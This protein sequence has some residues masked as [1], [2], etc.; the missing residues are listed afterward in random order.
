MSER[1]YLTEGRFI[2]FRGLYRITQRTSRRTKTLW[3]GLG[4][5][6][7]FFIVLAW[8]QFSTPDMPDNDGYYHIRFA[9]LMRTQG[10]KPDFPWLPLT[11]LNPRE[12]YDHHFLFHVALIP[13]TFGDLRLGAK[14]AS[15]T[16][17]SL[18]FLSI[19]WLLRG[20]RVRYAALWALGLLVVSQAFLF[21]MSIT[22]AQSLSLAVLA[23]GLHWMF[24]GKYK[25]LLP[26]AFVYVWMYDAFPLLILAALVYML[27]VWLTERRLDPSP[28]IYTSAGVVLGLVI[29]PYFPANLVFIYR[30]LL[31]K[32][33]ET[34]TVSVGNEWY[35]YTTLQLSQNSSLALLAFLA[36]VLALGLRGERI[37]ARTAT[38][39]F[40]AVL[41]GAMLF[42]SRR[43]IEYYAPFAVVFA[44]L[45]WTPLLRI[46]PA[47]TGWSRASVRTWLPGL[48]LTTLLVFGAWRTLPDARESVQSSKPYTL[49]AAATAWLQA[50]T[51]PGERIFQTD[52]DD[53]PRLFFYNTH[54]TYLIGLDPTY[55]Q[56]YDASRYDQWLR[57]TRGTVKSPSRSILADFGASYVLS[58]LQHGDFIRQAEADPAIVEVY[59]D[60]QAVIYAIR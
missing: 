37:D 19:W 25:L 52:W 4:L 16:F 56:L 10:L 32:L 39:L 2:G 51:P 1:T 29:N 24:T 12:F 7:A 20:Q 38:A 44:A 30:H 47:W 49:F 31:P 48:A 40:L 36:G 21:R 54:N 45:A 34:T 17:A 59:R 57:I 26:L 60:D 3:I 33:V 41:F 28:L 50:N 46:Q 13:F 53:F 15:V 6:A 58:D 5:L 14:W 35:P 18:A 27:A 11:I 22:R 9:E 55:L 43:F 42:Q 23:L 8:V